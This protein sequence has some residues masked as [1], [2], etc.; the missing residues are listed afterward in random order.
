MKYF[1]IL[2]DDFSRFRRIISLKRKSEA[3]KE[4]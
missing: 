4:I 1:I 3:E 2:I